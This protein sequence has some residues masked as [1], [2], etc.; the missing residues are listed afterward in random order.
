METLPHIAALTGLAQPFVVGAG[1]GLIWLAPMLTFSP[2]ADWIAAKF[3]STPPRLGAFRALKESRLKLMLGIVVAWVLGGF[4]E[5]LVLRGIVLQLVE[6]G[7]TPYLGL[8]AAD[9]LAI[10]V[11]AALAYV[12]HLY[13][14]PRAALIVAQLSAL[15]GLLFL[16]SGHNLW[17]V[18]LCHGI[19][20]TIA[21]VRFANGTS[22][23]SA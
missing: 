6:T 12:L 13:Q 8:I 9:A 11:A 1:F 14:G 3:A 23:Y 10:F 21:F 4:I 17:A 7:A 19:Y 18:I 22:R 5:E 2:V 15:F 16:I 20:D